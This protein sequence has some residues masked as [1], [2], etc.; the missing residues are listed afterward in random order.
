MSKD[1]IFIGI[2]YAL[3]CIAFLY[4]G[5]SYTN[6]YIFF[7]IAAIFG[8]FLAFNIGANDVANAFG[9]SVGAKTLTIKQALIIA[10]IF[11]FSGAFFAGGEVTSTIKSG[12]ITNGES[13]QAKYFAFVMMSAL[14]SSSIW[15]FIATFKSLPVSSTH[16]IIGGIL[17]A[18]LC[19]NAININPSANIDWN[20]IL[21]IVSSWVISP[22]M[23][24]ILS[25]IIYALIFKF[26]L[27][28][29]KQKTIE[30]KNIKKDKENYKKDYIDTFMQSDKSY[31]HSE[32]YG[33]LLNQNSTYNE[34]MKEFNKAEKNLNINKLLSS[35]IPLL[36][37]LIALVISTMLFYKALKNVNTGLSNFSTILVILIIC[38]SAYILS[39]GIINIMKKGEPK[40]AVNRIFSWFQIFT[41]C[42]FAF[43]HGANDISNAVGPFIAI[44]DYLHENTINAKAAVPTF[45]MLV[46]SFSL[47]LGLWYLGKSVIKTVGKNLAKIK[48]TT[49][50]SAEFGAAIVILLATAFGIPISSTH[51]L[52]GAVLGIGVFNKNANFKTMKPIALAWVVTLPASAFISAIAFVLL[53]NFL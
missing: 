10:A 23:G 31:Q 7:I 40:K 15:I 12:I 45:V 13:M 47:V 1:N 27:V 38:V 48:P 4:W 2:A 49:G 51:V 44:L 37:S 42:T 41:A 5:Y 19:L 18:A 6:A 26:I 11:E 17:G 30:L 21:T 39:S 20:V 36:A 3:V 14:I 32:L 33:I 50:F 52:I 29:I 46:F 43:S 8:F 53:Y 9:T 16:S 22:L 35:R 24:G 28:P 25:Y 34:K